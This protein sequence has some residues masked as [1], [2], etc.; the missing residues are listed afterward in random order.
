MNVSTWAPDGVDPG[1]TCRGK[2]PDIAGKTPRRRDAGGCRSVT[3]QK[4][5]QWATQLLTWIKAPLGGVGD[6]AGAFDQEA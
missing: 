5:C 1:Q 3:S 4:Y 6:T 2:A